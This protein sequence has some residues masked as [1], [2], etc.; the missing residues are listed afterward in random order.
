LPELVE[1][2]HT[3]MRHID[4]ASAVTV[5]GRG[6]TGDVGA[7]EVLV[8]PG[9]AREASVVADIVVD[10]V[11]NHGV[12]P[13]DVCVLVKQKIAQYAPG[14]IGALNTRGI[15]ARDESQM[16]DLLAEPVTEAVVSFLGLATNRVGREA[17]VKSL[18][19]LCA[20]RGIDD[21]DE[22][23]VF[24][25]EGE[26]SSFL[27][28]LRS[29]LRT[30]T[31]EAAVRDII[32][33]IIGFVGEASFRRLYPQYARGSHYGTILANLASRLASYRGSFRDWQESIANFVGDDTVP[34]MTVHKSKGLEYDTVVF[35]G[36]E[37]SSFW[38]F[39]RQP[40]EDT[41]AFFVAFSRAKRH[42]VFT[43]CENR[44]GVVQSRRQIGSLY[45]LL[46][47]A[48]VTI[49]RIP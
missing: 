47:Q 38:S 43:F 39:A 30:A 28:S 23:G 20:T 11:S 2:Q 44:G 40:R 18:S 16:Q 17:W 42:V 33:K 45:E 26:I 6:A 35:I 27:A 13:R 29:S 1:V 8:V 9:E 21:S 49:R 10:A 37:D 4:A 14:V 32:G 5:S 7:C 19:V 41:C 22:R 46:S 3:L 36:L 15:K 25:I 12:T 48:G 34:I 24:A 31:N